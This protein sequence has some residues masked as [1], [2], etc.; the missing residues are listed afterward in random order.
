LK[1]SGYENVQVDRV[2]KYGVSNDAEINNSLMGRAGNISGLTLFSAANNR[3]VDNDTHVLL[4]ADPSVSRYGNHD[5]GV[6][7]GS[8]FMVTVVTGEDKRG[9]AEEILRNNGGKL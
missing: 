3:F 7:G 5:Y 9:Q 1:S 8:F 4:G 6:T 2:S